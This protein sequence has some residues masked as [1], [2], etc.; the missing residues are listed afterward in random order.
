VTLLLAGAW[1]FLC[2]SV[3]VFAYKSGRVG[4]LL[5][6]SIAIGLMFFAGRYLSSC[7]GGELRL[8]T[9]LTVGT[10][11]VSVLPIVGLLVVDEL[12]REQ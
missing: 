1:V 12:Q 6:S 10:W 5:A 11:A 3:W 7:W 9:P 8:C 4:R 2:L